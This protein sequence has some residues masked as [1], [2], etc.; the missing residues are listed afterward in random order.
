MSQEKVLKIS[1]NIDCTQPSCMPPMPSCSDSSS[2]RELLCAT[3]LPQEQPQARPADHVKGLCEVDENCI[4]VSVLFSALLLQLPSCKVHIVRSAIRPESAL[5]FWYDIVCDILVAERTGFLL[6][7][8]QQWIAA[9]CHDSS[10]NRTSLPS[11][12][13][14]GMQWLH[15]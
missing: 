3:E 14:W 9:R 15:P 4:Q 6:E 11:S 2:L 5:C 10:R 1:F 12:C 7:F 13:R 8:S